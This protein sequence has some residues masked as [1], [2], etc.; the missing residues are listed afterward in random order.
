MRLFSFNPAVYFSIFF[1][2]SINVDY[3]LF[4]IFIFLNISINASGLVS[5]NAVMK[6]AGGR[7]SGGK[8]CRRYCHDRRYR[9]DIDLGIVTR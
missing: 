3:E 8:S 5:D 9:V 1:A 6:R 7:T 4:Q 2:A